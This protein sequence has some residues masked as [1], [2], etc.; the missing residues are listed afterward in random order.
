MEALPD[1]DI[2]NEFLE[3]N[4]CGKNSGFSPTFSIF[5][6]HLNGR[7]QTDIAGTCK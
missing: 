4:R 3:L 1:F 5:A 2:V 7:N 6:A